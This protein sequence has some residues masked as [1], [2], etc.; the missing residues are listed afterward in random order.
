MPALLAFLPL[1]IDWG[2]ATMAGVTVTI[3]KSKMEALCRAWQS[4]EIKGE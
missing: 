1:A 2:G 4:R 3:L